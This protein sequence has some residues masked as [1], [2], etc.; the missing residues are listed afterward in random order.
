MNPN[1][2]TPDSRLRSAAFL[3][4]ALPTAVAVASFAHGHGALSVGALSLVI[5]AAI[6]VGTWLGDSVLKSLDSLRRLNARST[7]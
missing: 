2:R 5:V 3:L 7:H 4:P 1:I 6:G